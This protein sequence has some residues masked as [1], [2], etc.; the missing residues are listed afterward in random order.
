MNNFTE[1]VCI[2]KTRLFKEHDICLSVLSKERGFFTLYAFGGAKSRRRFVGC[3]DAFTIAL[4]TVQLHPR[5]GYLTLQEATLVSSA[6]HML[7]HRTYYGIVQNCALFLQSSCRSGMYYTP[8]IYTLFCDF[9]T[10]FA[11]TTS[12]SPSLPLFFRFVVVALLGYRPLL[13]SCILCSKHIDAIT[14]PFFSVERGGLLCHSC[15]PFSSALRLFNKETL[16][17]LQHILSFNPSYWNTIPYSKQSIQ[18]A[19]VL[20]DE[21][22]QYHLGIVWNNGRFIHV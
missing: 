16:Y 8:G 7:S 1:T 18:E 10:M 6:K 12:I 9:L 14:H 5:K 17:V 19:C 4:C 15:Y 3:L 21:Y 2:M 13:D 11:D 20:I 22:V